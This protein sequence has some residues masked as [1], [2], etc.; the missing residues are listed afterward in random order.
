MNFISIGGWCGTSIALNGLELIKTGSIPFDYVRSSIEGVID[1]IENDF[2]NFFPK[3]IKRDLRYPN[4]NAFIGQ[5]IGFYHHNLLDNNIIES[6]KRKI[7]RFDDK[8]KQNNCIFLRTI[9]Q[10]NCN[11]EIKHYQKLQQVIDNKYPNISYIICFIIPNQN[12]TQYYKNLDNRT[13][14]F[15]L[16]DLSYNLDNL[17]N[18]YKPIFDFI[19]DN[20]LFINIPEPNNINIVLRP[21]RL[22]LVDGHPMVNYTN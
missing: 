9:V 10:E 17:K 15:T 14:L 6:F 4:W 21:S 11:D 16:N 13:F 2:I 7:N 1:C 22:W 3:E 12:V 5:Y 19:I 20:N 8:I 18:E